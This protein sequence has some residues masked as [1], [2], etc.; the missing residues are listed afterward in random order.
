MAEQIETKI[1]EYLRANSTATPLYEHVDFYHVYLYHQFG[2]NVSITSL[3]SREEL[4]DY[5]AV[6]IRKVYHQTGIVIDSSGIDKLVND[7]YDDYKAELD[8]LDEWTKSQGTFEER[9]KDFVPDYKSL[10]AKY[11]QHVSDYHENILYRQSKRLDAV[12]IDFLVKFE[13]SNEN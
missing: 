1:L 10:L 5:F 3:L 8:E 9:E 6:R 12:E 11:M 2:F 13:E 4:T 7:I